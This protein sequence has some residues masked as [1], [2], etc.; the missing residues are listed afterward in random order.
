[1]TWVICQSPDRWAAALESLIQVDSGGL[2]WGLGLG[3]LA[4]FPEMLPARDPALRTTLLMFNLL[5]QYF[6]GLPMYVNTQ[7][8]IGGASQQSGEGN[9]VGRS[10]VLQSACHGGLKNLG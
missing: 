4:S 9:C 10:S 6:V 3:I 1:M 2:G 8:S 7:K 5:Y